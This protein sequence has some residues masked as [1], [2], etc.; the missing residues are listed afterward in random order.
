MDQMRHRLAMGKTTL[1]YHCYRPAEF[2]G[3][4]QFPRFHWVVATESWS[5]VL[6]LVVAATI[7]A[8]AAEL[9]VYLLM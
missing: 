5:V 4:E 8:G 3:C 7:A 1:E 2:D 9:A 6:I